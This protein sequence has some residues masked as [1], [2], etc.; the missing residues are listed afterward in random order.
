LPLLRSVLCAV[1]AVYLL[2]GVAFGALMPYFPGN[3]LAFWLVTSAICLALGLIHF[4]GL[5]QV[6]PRL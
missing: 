3:S 2:R 5:R 6:W 1:T 4:F